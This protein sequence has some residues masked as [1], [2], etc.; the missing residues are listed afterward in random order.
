M[1]NYGKFYLATSMK[2]QRSRVLNIAHVARQI[3]GID[4]TYTREHI[5]LT[6][7]IRT[8]PSGKLT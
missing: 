6:G 1:G 5:R 2:R 4:Q 8:L 3:L 7:L